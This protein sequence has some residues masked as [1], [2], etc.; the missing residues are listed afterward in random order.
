M[1]MAGIQ[2]SEDTLMIGRLITWQNSIAL[3]IY[4]KAPPLRK[5]ILYGKWIN[6]G[7]FQSSQLTRN[8]IILTTRLVVG[9]GKLETNLECQNSSQSGLFHLA[10]GQESGPIS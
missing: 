10:H 9:H 3:S 2:A 6:K 7:D 1:L 4:S 8:S 5:T